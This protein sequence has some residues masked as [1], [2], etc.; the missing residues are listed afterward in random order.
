MSKIFKKLLEAKKQFTAI[1]KDQKNPHFKS[2]Y[3]DINDLHKMVDPILHEQG[4]LITSPIV[5]G[6]MTTKLIDVETGESIESSFKIEYNAN[7]QKV[8]SEI[9]Y[10]RRYLLSS[11]LGLQAED[12]DG[13]KASTKPPALKPLP[14]VD[15]VKAVEAIKAGKVTVADILKTRTCTLE[16]IAGLNEVEAVVNNK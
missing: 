3:Y 9:T 14:K 6:V 8:G 1:S 11:L 15:F 4:L 13:N 5:D 12:D 16:E 10:Y 2:A 7:P